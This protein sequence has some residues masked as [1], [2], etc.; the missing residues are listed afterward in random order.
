MHDE[1][2]HTKEAPASRLRGRGLLINLGKTTLHTNEEQ[3]RF[4][5]PAVDVV[6][7]RRSE[8]LEGSVVFLEGAHVSGL[9]HYS[10]D[11]IGEFSEEVAKRQ[12]GKFGHGTY[13]G[14]GDLKGETVELLKAEGTIRHGAVFDGNVA[15][16]HRYDVLRAAEYLKREKNMPISRIKTSIPNAPLTDLFDDVNF[17]G[18]SIDAVMVLMDQEGGAVE[19]VVAPKATHQI[20]IT[21]TKTV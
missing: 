8:E 19:L 11:H 21:D 17:D 5:V 10:V 7:E 9:W 15:V 18:R 3:E 14:A 20:T 16:V 4:A 6:A 2:R 1:I 12:G 13:F